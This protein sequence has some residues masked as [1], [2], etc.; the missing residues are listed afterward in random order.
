MSYPDN[1]TSQSPD[2]SADGRYI[3]FQ[4][5]AQNL[6]LET[7]TYGYSDIFVFDRDNS[8]MQWI[9]PV[10]GNAQAMGN[11]ESPIISNDGR[12]TAF[13]SYSSDLPGS[14]T[15]DQDT[16][17]YDGI[18]SNTQWMN[19]PPGTPF[20]TETYGAYDIKV[21]GSGW[22]TVFSSGRNDLVLGDTNGKSDIFLNGFN[23]PTP[24]PTSTP[25]LTPLPTLTPTFTPTA[26]ITPTPTLTPT[27]TPSPTSTPLPQPQI[28]H[29]CLQ[30][31]D[32]N[33][34]T[35]IEVV[36]LN[37]DGVPV[38]SGT[39]TGN[40][41]AELDQ[42]IGD[43]AFLSGQYKLKVNVHKDTSL[44]MQGPFYPIAR[45]FEADP[46]QVS[47]NSSL[48]GWQQSLGSFSLKKASR[49]LSVKITEAGTA[50]GV[51]GMRI[52][53]FQLGNSD[54][55]IYKDLKGIT[56]SSGQAL[57]PIPPDAAGAYQI[58][59]YPPQ[60]QGFTEFHTTVSPEPQGETVVEGTVTRANA[61]L[62]VNLVDSSGNAFA[63]AK[64][65][66]SINCMRK[67]GKYRFAANLTAAQSTVELGLIAGSY[68]CRAFIGEH[69]ASKQTVSL[70]PGASEAVKITVYAKTAPVSLR[71]LDSLQQTLIGGYKA[72]F[73]LWTTAAS[74]EIIG[75]E[76]RVIVESSTGKADVL[77]LK[78]L[79]Y[80][81]GVRFLEDA[82]YSIPRALI[83]V[84]SDGES[85]KTVDFS[86]LLSSAA[87]I[88][89]VES[90][91]EGLDV[92]GRVEAVSHAAADATA[93]EFSA[94]AALVNGR[95]RA[96]NTEGRDLTA[97]AELKDGQA[98]LHLAP[99][100]RY[101]VFIYPELDSSEY[102]P[103]KPF[104]VTLEAGEVRE[105][106]AKLVQSNHKLKVNP[107]LGSSGE[108]S[109]F[110]CNA[111]SAK[112]E[113]A[114]SFS[115]EPGG[116][117]E[118]ELRAPR[119]GSVWQ[120]R[121][122]GILQGESGDEL[123]LG[124]DSYKPKPGSK[125]GR[126]TVN[127][128]KD[129]PYYPDSS[130]SFDVSQDTSFILADGETVVDI[131][132]YA[133]GGSGTGVMT[134]NS[135][136]GFTITQEG[137]PLVTFDLDFFVDGEKV[138]QTE[139]PVNIRFPVDVETLNEF[140]VEAWHLISSR[141]DEDAQAWIQDGVFL[142]DPTT[143][144]LSVSV[145]HFS[146]WGSLIDRAKAAKEQS[147]TKLKVKKVRKSNSN[148][149]LKAAK[150]LCWKPPAAAADA[151]RYRVELLRSRKKSNKKLNWN[152]A[153]DI[154]ATENCVTRTLRRGKYKYRVHVV[155]GSYSAIRSFN[156]R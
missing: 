138:E 10:T 147:P 52:Q 115:E 69:A 120:V 29:L 113:S 81:A 42:V 102:I 125:R 137:Y 126:L 22:C 119:G 35:G 101:K 88:V 152:K 76:D 106:S 39:S 85:L 16:Y 75:I 83:K 104:S 63:N 66:D 53:A 11:C 59:A 140:G 118:L 132:A 74:S 43:S 37:K 25:T 153:T 105:V 2:M 77:L 151:Q 62:T 7:D 145:S 150:K 64:S 14:G 3:V 95:L 12:F 1:G 109:Y 34:A 94:A 47:W 6:T 123:Y 122:Y 31:P 124:E 23:I 130:Y 135:G 27:I 155:D 68:E 28:I 67:D 86:A 139:Y 117:L 146:I 20:A 72:E 89:K 32:G 108:L 61:K 99:E 149:Y 26:T 143:Q 41:C 110:S 13:S 84:S 111:F 58:Y 78:G 100:R 54:Q 156:V 93:A 15:G 103:P 91:D 92:S 121:C 49:Y 128:E 114:N 21:A 133:F 87:L 8:S 38:R 136:L 4:S 9:K 40:G 71:L 116:S 154:A 44:Q 50:Q 45:L 56:D 142:Y 17:V 90:A 141:F 112:G 48:E 55:E 60:F 79:E 73:M 18:S 96:W 97:N 131:P 148:G 144:T 65:T 24:T 36:V 5:T 127:L 30:L 19:A 80:Q 70:E 107:K 98:L 33:P 129:R 82:P 51:A 134:V 57:L 46:N